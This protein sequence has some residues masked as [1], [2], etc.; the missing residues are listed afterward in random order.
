MTAGQ[1]L[2]GGMLDLEPQKQVGANTAAQKRAV[3]FNAATAFM[4]KLPRVP[5]AVFT[6]EPAQAL[7]AQAPTSIVYCDTSS[8]MQEHSPGVSPHLLARYVTIRQ[9]DEISMALRVSGMIFYVIRGNGRVSQ[10]G[11][12]VNW[13]EGDVFILPGGE[14]AVLSAGDQ[15]AVLWAVGDEP[16][17]AFQGVQPERSAQ[18]VRTHIVHYPAGEIARQLDL[19]YSIDQEASTAARAL[20]FSSDEQAESRNI[21]PT[22]TLAL[23]SLEPGTTQRSHRHN[24]VAVTLII[25][26]EGCFSDVDGANKPWQQ[27]ATTITPPQAVHSHTNTGSNRALFLIVQDG[28]LYSHAR[29]TGF[30]FA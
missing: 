17:M 25:Q 9:D 3:Y 22:L 7:A 21:L 26:G 6:N 28:G 20:M 1:K 8:D 27:W 16:F 5:D 11:E 18:V 14:D 4:R 24:A 2:V 29:A 12:H 13:H 30:A 15:G 23:N 19:I 10:D